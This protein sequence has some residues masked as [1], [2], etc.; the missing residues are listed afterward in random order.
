MRRSV[1]ALGFAF[2]LACDGDS[3][4]EP[5]ANLAG[6]WNLTTVNGAALPF[7]LGG[8]GADL[9]VELVGDQIVA[10]G[11]K[12]WIGTTTYR[13]TESGT[14]STITQ[15]P[16]GTWSQSGANVTLSYAGG[17]VAYATIAG[18]V[19]TFSAPGVVAVYVRE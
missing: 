10:Y 12:T 7:L 14:V 11:D 8:S 6:T 5:G 3:P 17:A 19:I 4:S 13:Q 9:T 15:V 16:S 18:D 1:L 2:A